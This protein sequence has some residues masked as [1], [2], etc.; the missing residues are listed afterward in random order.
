MET[1]H[2]GPFSTMITRHP[3]DKQGAPTG[4]GMMVALIAHS[5]KHIKKL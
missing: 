4:N 5:A 2:S 1:S 3:F